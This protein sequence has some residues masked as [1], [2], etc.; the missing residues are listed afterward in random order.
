M[1]KVFFLF[2]AASYISH[3]HE[4]S[5]LH[6]IGEETVTDLLIGFIR[7][8]HEFNFDPSHF[9]LQSKF[10]LKVF[11][12][13]VSLVLELILVALGNL[14]E[15]VE[16]LF[17]L[18]HHTVGVSRVLQAKELQEAEVLEHAQTVLEEVVVEQFVVIGSDLHKGWDV[19]LRIAVVVLLHTACVAAEEFNDSFEKV[20]SDVAYCLGREAFVG[21]SF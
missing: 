7:R 1:E 2:L 11:V 19:K 9:L 15:V 10:L 18:G 16:N 6:L 4:R 14:C 21:E 5:V 12:C 3:H 20:R 13:I 17:F 8:G